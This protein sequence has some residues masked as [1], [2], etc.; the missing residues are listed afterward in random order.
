LTKLNLGCGQNKLEGYVNV[1][2]YDS[3]GPE[4][5]WNL[6]VTPWPLEDSCASE[7]VMHHS[8]EHMGADVDVFLA[9]MKELYRVAAPDAK[10][11][12]SVPHPRS[13]GFAGDPTHVRPITPAILS[14]FSKKKN[15]EWKQL[16]WPNTPLATYIDVDFDTM[17]VTITLT[18]RWAAQLEAGQI[19]REGLDLAIECYFNVVDELR[20]TLKVCKDVA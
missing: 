19:N 15:L 10:I 7:I 5:V 18:P 6:E 11:V 8:L 16:G 14:L 13:E 9:V 3:F 17:D 12:I 20:I 2:R 4:L 1:D